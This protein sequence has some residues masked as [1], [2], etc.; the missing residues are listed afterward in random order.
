MIPTLRF[1]YVSGICLPY[2]TFLD[3]SKMQQTVLAE[4][5]NYREKMIFLQFIG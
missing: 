4:L 5:C 2:L 3:F 1:V